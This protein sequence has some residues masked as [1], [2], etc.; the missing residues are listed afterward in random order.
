MTGGR[1][2]EAAD[3]EPNGLSRPGDRRLITSAGNR[4]RAGAGGDLS[5]HGAAA[6]RQPGRYDP[7][8]FW[9]GDHLGLS[10]GFRLGGE[11]AG[12]LPAGDTGMLSG[13]AALG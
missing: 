7:G 11:I 8:S 6:R 10:D 5:G 1:L 9:S 13:S 3:P 12:Q 4:L 2:A